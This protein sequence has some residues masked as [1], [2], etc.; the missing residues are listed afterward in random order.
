MLSTLRLGTL[1]HLIQKNEPFQNIPNFKTTLAFTSVNILYNV[2][3]G[4]TVAARPWAI[5]NYDIYE[6]AE[7]I[8]PT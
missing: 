3:I 8:A 7:A 4:Q 5:S 2:L 1:N 6:L